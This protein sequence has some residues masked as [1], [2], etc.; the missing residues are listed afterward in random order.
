M[1]IQKF[2]KK[3]FSQTTCLLEE[4]T[5]AVEQG[6]SQFRPSKYSTRLLMT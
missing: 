2:I 5:G 1:L 4:E 3:F 6:R